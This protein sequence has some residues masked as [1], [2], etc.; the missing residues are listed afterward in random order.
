C[1]ITA[2]N[3][4]PDAAPLHVLPHLWYRN[5]WS[6]QTTEERPVIR[7]VGPGA[8]YT[9]HPALGERWWYARAADNQPVELLVTENDPNLERLDTAP[10]PPPY[11]RMGSTTHSC[12]GRSAA[13]TEARGASWPDTRTRWCRPAPRSR[14]RSASAR[15][16][17]RTRSPSSIRSSPAGA[18]R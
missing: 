13:S 2:V 1:R 6:W 16:R 11:V 12:K 15:N 18:P 3:R 4:G 5:T 14:F 7:A 8:A 9:T 10:T 17:S